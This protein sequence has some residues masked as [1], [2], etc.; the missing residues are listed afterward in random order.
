MDR[1]RG[2]TAKQRELH[3]QRSWGRTEIFKA[4]VAALRGRKVSGTE[5]RNGDGRGREVARSTSGWVTVVL[6]HFGCPE[7]GSAVARI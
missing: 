6:G 4:S 7:A 1:T 5:D 3:V 2:G